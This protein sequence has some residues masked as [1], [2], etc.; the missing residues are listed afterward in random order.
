MKQL[1]EAMIKAGL[2]PEESQEPPKTST[3][4]KHKTWRNK[5]YK[6]RFGQPATFELWLLSKFPRN[7][8]S[9][10]GL[11]GKDLFESV[12]WHY[13]VDNKGPSGTNRHINVY[14][15]PLCFVHG[16]KYDPDRFPPLKDKE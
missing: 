14:I 10:C 6:N 3:K 2:V 16:R 15:C 7:W 4:P 11:C 1:R 8:A 5:A 13:D 9:K 12:E